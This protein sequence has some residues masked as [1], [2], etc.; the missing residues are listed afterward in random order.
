[1]STKSV[2]M[3]DIWFK[4]KI[5]VKK[6]GAKY[7][8]KKGETKCPTGYSRCNLFTCF[9]GSLCPWSGIVIRTTDKFDKL[10]PKPPAYTNKY[11]YKLSCPPVYKHIGWE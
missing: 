5:Y 2:Q 6:L 7:V 1:M 10:K 9:K 3:S 11:A 8:M 4:N